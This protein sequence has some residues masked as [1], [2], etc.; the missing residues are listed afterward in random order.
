ML[1]YFLIFKSNYLMNKCEFT[2]FFAYEEIIIYWIL[3]TI[4]GALFENTLLNTPIN[5]FPRA[6]IIT[7][8]VKVCSLSVPMI[9]SQYI[10]H[11]KSIVN[12]NSLKLYLLKYTL[13]QE[14]S[15]PHFT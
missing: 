4:L 9:L 15:V 6:I 5:T 10:L 8:V 12:D 13:C 7:S 2:F 14:L 11:A 1:P 3:L